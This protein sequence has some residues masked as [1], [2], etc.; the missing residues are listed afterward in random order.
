MIGLWTFFFPESFFDDFPVSGASW[1]STLGEYN[2]HL[3]R[4]YGAAQIGLAVAAI[5][6]G[7]RGGRAGIGFVLGGY[8]VFGA[9]HFGF[10]VGTFSS[11]STASAV[12]QGLALATSTVLPAFVLSGLFATTEKGN[13][14]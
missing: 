12:T 7:L 10:H 4:D 2:E 5:G 6:V 8:V 14:T 3:T 11:F 13:T 9:L 1:V